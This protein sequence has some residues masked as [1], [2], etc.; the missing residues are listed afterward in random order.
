MS[1]TEKVRNPRKEFRQCFTQAIGLPTH[2]FGHEE[3]VW[4]DQE[5]RMHGLYLHHYGGRTC[6]PVWRAQVNYITPRPIWRMQK[7]IKIGDTV[8]HLQPGYSWKNEPDFLFISHENARNAFSFELSFHLDELETI[9]AWLGEL[10]TAKSVG[11]DDFP[12]PPVSFTWRQDDVLGSIFMQHGYLWTEK[13][14]ND[15]DIALEQEKARKALRAKL[16]AEW[17]QQAAIKSGAGTRAENECIET[18][19]ITG[20][21]P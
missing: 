10:L 7:T 12:A 20:A 1:S 9:A 11:A 3:C 19:A 5:R 14:E 2:W 4:V 17:K 8:W 15:Y 18:S 16:M 13:A 21:R 6:P